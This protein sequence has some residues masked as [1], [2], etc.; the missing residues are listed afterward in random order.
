MIT[1]VYVP[2]LRSAR[3]EVTMTCAGVL[4]VVA[5]RR[6]HDS[7]TTAFQPIT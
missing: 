5:L 2:S 7:L 6:T 4:P 1:A 3:L